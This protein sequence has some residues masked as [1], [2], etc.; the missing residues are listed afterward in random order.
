MTFAVSPSVT[1]REIDLTTIVPAVSSTEGALAG[2]FR[3]GPVEKRILIDSENS[4]ATRFGKP[5]N[6][7]PETWFTAASFLA[8]GNRLYISRAADTTG[9]N[10]L[11]SYVGNSTNL[12]AES[13]NNSLRLANS[14]VGNTTGLAAGM[15]I[16]FSNST[17]IP[18]GAVIESVNSTCVVL[19][20]APTSN[21]T[22]A[23]VVFRENIAY[24][25][26]AL[27]SDLSYDAT[28]IGDWDNQIVK[29]DDH[30][31]AREAN[32]DTF[33]V[34]VLYAARYPGEMGN[35]LRVSV[36][37]SVDQ[38]KSNTDLT[39]N[40]QFNTTNS[41]ACA[42]TG[43]VG[44][45]T[46]TV[47]LTPANTANVTQVATINAFAVTVHNLLNVGDLVEV[48]NTRIG[49]QFLQVT[50][51]GDVSNNGSNVFSFTLQMDDELKL[52]TNSRND[53]VTRFWEFYR[54]VDV[55]PAQSEYMLQFGNTD[56]NDELHIVV[57]DELGKFSGSPG[58]I[59]EIHRNVSRASDAKS[60]DGADMYYKDVINQRSKYIWWANDRTTAVSN[61]AQFLESSSAQDPLNMT[62]IGGADG[63]NEQDVPFGTLAFAYDYF[64]SAEDVDISLVLQGKARGEAITNY[65]QLGN[66]IIDNICEHRLDCVGFISP[67]YNDVV[68]NP[69]E[70][71]ND[72]V[73]FRNQLRSTSYAVM[74]SGYKYMYD[75]YND[76]YR[77]IPLNG[78][79]AGLCVRT[80][81][82][83]D[84]WWS[85]A[86]YNR[87]Q[88]KNVIRLAYNPRRSDRDTL[89]KAG[90]NPVISQDGQ[91]TLLFGDKTLL[92]KP[93]AFDRINV[94]RLFIVLEKA[95]STASKYTLFEFNDDFT[96]A[97]FRNLINPYL[98]DVKGR[99]GI[100][101]FLV[102]CDAT[103]NTPE[104]IDRNEFIGDIYIKPARS[105]NFILLNFIA[106][107]TGVAFSEVV[108]KF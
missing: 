26:V 21:V 74:D 32:G 14:T 97:Q 57:V 46:L 51:L 16:L 24:S 70:E 95:I 4:L 66:Y 82:T 49:L 5:T 7:N 107:R 89:Y 65:T 73:E 44:S 39:P 94:R 17:Y 43:V 96:R 1:I 30:Y 77:W 98:R 40:A 54:S 56:A 8:Y 15:K 13:G 50:S 35:S 19:S 101:D 27:Q 52:S 41:L 47:T 3:W 68:Y 76:V 93:S 34:A 102:V 86:G 104:V 28:D 10:F 63:P 67:D 99:R 92:A 38:F 58:T 20:D 106:V 22:A 69:F 61:T 25:A 6:F 2:V 11:K 108:G 42:L 53:Y 72:V 87:G 105:I 90:V 9:N 84:P 60:A 79:I 64:A 59:L 37:D 23:E 85:P 29:N 18:V 45:N 78:D 36:C 33:D 80:D 100:Y 31:A 83:N 81:A 55:E 48:G 91:G 88:I 12:V 62:M 75:K 103:N 71:A